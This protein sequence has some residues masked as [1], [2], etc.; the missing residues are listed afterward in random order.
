MTE[1]FH[2]LLEVYSLWIGY[3]PEI[4]DMRF[5]SDSDEF[6]YSTHHDIHFSAN[7]KA[8]LNKR[9]LPQNI[10]DFGCQYDKW[11]EIN[12]RNSYVFRMFRNALDGRDIIQEARATILIQCLEGYWS[13][14]NSKKMKKFDDDIKE[15]IVGIAVDSIENSNDLILKK[16]LGIDSIKV[17]V[18]NSV[19]GLLNVI[20]QASLRDKILFAIDYTPYTRKVFEHE[21]NEKLF[22]E[23]TRLDEFIKKTVNHRNFMSHLFN[24]EEYFDKRENNLAIK[25]LELLLRLCFLYDIGLD[26]TEKS[27]NEQI[28]MINSEFYGKRLTY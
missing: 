24:P 4:R 20:N 23:K 11:V 3:F 5:Y 27:L 22:K 8:N 2:N 21:R 25:K 10:D 19:N 13:T 1:F 17:M 16:F 15:K 6:I 7:G 12:K 9:L 26:I 28:K 18:L 14:H